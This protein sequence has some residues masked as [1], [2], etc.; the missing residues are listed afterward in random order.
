MTS[1]KRLNNKIELLKSLH[2]KI[3]NDKFA[4]KVTE[5]EILALVDTYFEIENGTLIELPCGI[6]AEAEE[7]L[8]KLKEEAQ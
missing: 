1:S 3:L 6:K 2:H 4:S 8:M 5:Q 7:N